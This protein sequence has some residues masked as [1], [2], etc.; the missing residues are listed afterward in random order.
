MGS[1]YTG[2]A[3]PGPAPLWDGTYT[4]TGSQT[5][6]PPEIWKQISPSPLETGNLG[7]HFSKTQSP[8]VL[9]Q[10][11]VTRATVAP[12]TP[13]PVGLYHTEFCSNWM[14]YGLLRGG[15]SSNWQVTPTL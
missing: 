15:I 4:P 6:A 3:G 13:N 11:R 12:S 14:F 2:D 8:T 5:L 1:A 10:E 7:G 9:S